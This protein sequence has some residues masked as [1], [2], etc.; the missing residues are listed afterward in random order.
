MKT[1]IINAK[2]A[3]EEGIT[4]LPLVVAYPAAVLK[5]EGFFIEVIDL[6]IENISNQE[7]FAKIRKINPDVIVINSETTVLQVKNYCHALELSRNIYKS[8]PKTYLAMMGAHVTFKDEET[9]KRNKHIDFIIRHEAEYVLLNLLKAL[10]FN[11]ELN[12]VNGI[13]YRKN[14]E[15]IRNPDEKPIEELDSLPFPARHLFPIDQYIKKDYETVVQGSRG[16]SNRCYFCHSSA[17]D[18]SLRFRNID[19]VIREIKEVLNMGFKSIYFADYD[20][21]AKEERIIEF[22]NKVIKEKIK[23]SWNC[24]I[25]ADRFKNE[26]SANKLLSLMKKA[27]CY[28]LFVGFESVSNEILNNSNKEVSSMQLYKAAEIIKN[29][30]VN[31]HA[32]FLFGLPGDTEETIKATV[33]FAKKINPQM[34]SFNILTPYVGTP[35]GDHPEKFGISISDKYWY[36]KTNNLE[37]NIAGNKNLSAEKLYQL[38]N[39]AYSDFLLSNFK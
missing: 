38:V 7:L 33:E 19:N 22:C 4:H 17:M 1:I 16:C 2:N 3:I 24:N 20:F 31:L 9:L 39:K 18:R 30:G 27:G 10:K 26:K 23:F 35:L 8:F 37:K 6:A 29:N 25:R 14:E 11:K 28:R 34:A 36:E 12:G 32:S 13:S 21:G 5:K 15:I